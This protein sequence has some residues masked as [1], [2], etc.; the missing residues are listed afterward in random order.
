[1]KIPGFVDLQVNGFHGVDF[2]SPQLTEGDFLRAADLLFRE[3]ISMFLPTVIT[4]H[5][6]IYRRNLPLMARIIEHP[7]LKSRIPGFHR[8]F[9]IRRIFCRSVTLILCA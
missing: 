9:L 3:G 5:P 1:M 7:E 4:S 2:S 8:D 6:A